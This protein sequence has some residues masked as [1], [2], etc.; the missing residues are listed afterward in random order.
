MPVYKYRTK[1]SHDED[2]VLHE[3]EIP[4]DTK[5]EAEAWLD[6]EYGVERDDDG[7][8][9]NSDVVEVSLISDKEA[10]K[11]A[12][13]KAKAEQKVLDGIA[14]AEQNEAIKQAN[15]KDS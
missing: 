1:G 13:K 10:A 14:E 6:K 4:A 3:H 12:E 9:I 2:F 15:S 11:M 7:K 8:Q 5:T